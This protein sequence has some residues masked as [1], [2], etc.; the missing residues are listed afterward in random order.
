MLTHV[1]NGVELNS[2]F[3]VYLILAFFVL[4]KFEQSAWLVEF[5]VFPALA[6]VCGFHAG[7]PSRVCTIVSVAPPTG[8]EPVSFSE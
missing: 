3:S 8:I 4:A 5:T 7:V 1:A 2:L 6:Q